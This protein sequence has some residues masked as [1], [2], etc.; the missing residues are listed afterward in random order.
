MT[1]GGDHVKTWK[2]D[3]HPQ[4][5]EREMRPTLLTPWFWNS[6]LQNCE[7]T[8]FWYLSHQ[9]VVFCFG[10]P[11]NPLHLLNSRK[12]CKKQQKNKTIIHKQSKAWK[13][14]GDLGRKIAKDLSLKMIILQKGF[15]FLKLLF[16]WIKIILIC[17]N[18]RI[19]ILRSKMQNLHEFSRLNKM[20][21]KEILQ[22]R[23]GTLDN[24]LTFPVTWC[25]FAL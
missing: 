4:T 17:G 22:Y 9:S 2:E 25:L 15:S 10:S 21:L 5:K 13:L 7:N 24:I 20:D 1:Q 14:K 19:G 12:L 23:W 8:H 16:F 3:G 11:S 18:G 6:R